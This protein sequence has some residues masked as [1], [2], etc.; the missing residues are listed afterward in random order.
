[1]TPSEEKIMH[2]IRANPYITQQEIADLLGIARSS[3]AVHI[4]HMMAKGDIL[5]RGY[6]LPEESSIKSAYACVVGGANLDVM[7]KPAEK[8]LMNESNPG[9]ITISAGGVGRNIAVNLSKMNVYTELI[10]PIGG[11]EP[12]NLINDSVNRFLSMKY[13]QTFLGETSSSY[14]ALFD[15]NGEMV[16]SVNDMSI[17]NKFTPSMLQDLFEVINDARVVVLDTNL[18]PETLEYLLNR[19]DT[20]CIVD[21]VSSVK[22]KRI[23]N[24]LDKIDLLKCNQYE[25]EVL[26]DV[27]ITDKESVLEAGKILR[28]KGV[29]TVVITAGMLG[30]CI[31]MD[32]GTYYFT[33]TPMEIANTTGAGDAF[34][35]M[36]AH[37]YMR[38]LSPIEAMKNAVAASRL[39][40][41]ASVSV[42][43]TL[44]AEELDSEK[45]E[46]SYECINF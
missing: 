13:S 5:G 14:V 45:N 4:S 29:R 31:F 25:A 37:G 44:N 22:A 33:S 12:T 8:L 46:I 32:E 43:S 3:V 10:V 18:I 21:S 40:L 7:A 17:M 15:E 30:S 20:Y 1:M 11:I 38:K 36:L 34:T 16:S 2:L 41:K 19:L 39:T 42:D 9:N 24:L 28:E 23:K 26:T 6:L 27:K 35:A